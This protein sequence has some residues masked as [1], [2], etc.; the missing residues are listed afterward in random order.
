MS[1]RYRFA[2]LSDSSKILS[3]RNEESVRLSSRNQA[4]ISIDQHNSWFTARV[5]NIQNEPILIFS[6]ENID[7]GFTRL[8]MIKPSNRTFD[9][10]IAVSAS[11]RNLGFGSSMLSSTKEV[12]RTF[13]GV[14]EINATVREGNQASLKLFTASGFKVFETHAGFVKL[15]FSLSE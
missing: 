7:I 4:L 10:S 15:R 13:L 8:D 1:I 9:V 3:W 11:F 14:D 2:Q 5:T 6:N 12:A